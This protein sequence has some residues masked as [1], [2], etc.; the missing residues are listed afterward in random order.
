MSRKN[1]APA[2][3]VADEGA[4]RN[5]ESGCD[6]QS[7]TDGSDGAPAMFRRRYS[8]GDR[9]RSGH[10]ETRC[11]RHQDAGRGEVAEVKRKTSREIGQSKS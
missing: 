6:R 5:P 8:N 3:L 1:R 10:K 9:I 2:D 4:E 7:R 11:E